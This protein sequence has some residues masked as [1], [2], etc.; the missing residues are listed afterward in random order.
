MNPRTD[1]ADERTRRANRRLGL[2]LLAIALVFFVGVFV[3]RL[4]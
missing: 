2:I 1:M 4:F 3:S